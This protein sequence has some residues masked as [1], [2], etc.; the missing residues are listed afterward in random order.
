MQE[1][2]VEGYRLSPQQ[3]RLWLRRSG[4]AYRAQCALLIEGDLEEQTLR[5]A[6]QAVV[7]RHQ[8]LRTV[9]SQLP[10]MVVPLQVIGE[11]EAVRP[12]LHRIEW[13]GPEGDDV[14]HLVEELLRREA[15]QPFDLERGPVLRAGLCRVSATRHFLVLTLPAICADAW[16]VG[17]LLREISR[18]YRGGPRASESLEDPT[19]YL[20]FSEWQN[21]LIEGTDEDAEAGRAYWGELIAARPPALPWESPPDSGAEFA[22]AAIPV[23]LGPDLAVRALRSSHR[24]A[25]DLPAFF[26]SSWQALLWRLTRQ[27]EVRVDTVFSGRKYDE[28]Q[29]VVGLLARSLPIRARVQPTMRFADLFRQTLEEMRE[30]EAWQEYFSGGEDD[31]KEPAVATVGFSFADRVAPEMAAGITVSMHAQ[32]VR[33]EPYKLH[34]SVLGGD[35]SLAAGLEYD[36]R[37]YTR[38][39]VARI[40]GEL[41]ALITSASEDPNARLLDLNILAEAERRTL[42]DEFNRTRTEYP[43]HESFHR[44]FEAQVARAPEAVAVAFRDER[45]SYAD[46]NARANRLARHLE[47]NGVGPD[48]CVGIAM[49]RSSDMVVGLLGILKA[50]GAY[51]PLDPAYP[52]E[53]LAWM[54]QDAAVSVLLTQERFLGLLPK[55]GAAAICLDADWPEISRENGANLETHGSPEN[56]AYVIYTSGSTGKPKGVM[57][58][59]RGLVNYLSWCVGA[60]RV[61]E[62]RGTLVHSSIGFDLTVTSLFS[63]LLVGK[64]VTLLPE[65]EGIEALADALRSGEGF[66]LVKITPS[67]LD[68]VNAL[69]SSGDT[70]GGAKA[71]VIG[72]EALSGESLAFWRDHA[73]QTRIINEFG[74]SETVVGCCIYEISAGA[75]RPGPVPIGRPIANTQIYLLDERLQPVPV[76]VV[77]ELYIGGD[78]LARGYRN[79]P[80][81]TAERFIPNPFGHRGGERLYETGD[82]ARRLPGGDLEYLGRVDEQVK[83]RGFRIEPGEIESVLAGHPGVRQCAVVAREDSPGDRRLVAYVVARPGADPDP[84]GL[85][86]FLLEKLPEPMVP[87]AFVRLAA[88]PLTPNGKV[89]RRA[90]PAPDASRSPEGAYRPPETPLQVTLA[91]IWKD[92]LR[93]QRVGLGDNFFELGGHSLLATRLISRL[94]QALGL[95]ISLRRVFEEPVLEGFAIAIV[96]DLAR[97]EVPEEVRR[98]LSEVSGLSEEEARDRLAAEDRH[99]DRGVSSAS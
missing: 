77:G 35:G 17:S 30:A 11:G 75:S 71:L 83:L 16:T 84:G 7:G 73:P 34:L 99:K 5:E 91:E 24:P 8:S 18:A 6:L 27:A 13:N 62:G 97:A 26:L 44:L 40:A 28:L 86:R 90:L 55:H 41:E 76:G 70:P 78:G 65:E 36:P 21:E 9:F 43:G 50:G 64:S 72:G 56:L 80:E 15:E 33:I 74:P 47:R 69:L 98:M 52:R 57:I 25:F 20:Q 42:V 23:H 48:T 1:Q 82:L 4:A 2:V 67:H 46:L 51:V 94:A 32:S 29:E 59:H 14:G 39:T 3:R 45:L 96:E 54:L 60:Y 19:Q 58:P 92:L 12:C 31:R 88:M 37:V 85:R 22:P 68:V 61:G 38:D 53:R 66:S 79:A 49:E 10:G 95:R 87:S 81:L 93:V 89:D 63:A